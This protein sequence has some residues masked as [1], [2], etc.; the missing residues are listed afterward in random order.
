MISTDDLRFF[1]TLSSSSSLAAAARAMDVTPPAVTQRLQQMEQRLG[2]RLVDRSGRRMVL[3]DEGDHLISGARRI[4]DQLGELTETLVARRGLVSGHLRVVAPLGFG[5]HYVAP[6]AAQFRTMY[7]EVTLSLMLSDR[8]AQ[9]ADDAWDL[10][11]YVGELRSSSLIAQSLAPNERFL[12]GTPEYFK[13]KGIPRHPSDLLKHNCIALREND[14]DVTMWRFTP[15]KRG[16][17]VG[18]RI[19]PAL[20]SNDGEVT[21]V[22]ALAGAGVILR[23]EWDVADDLRTGRLVRVLEDWK[24]PPANIVAL[25]GARRGRSARTARFLEHLHKVLTPAPWRLQC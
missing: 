24:L 1:A 20:S 11:L 5:R 15:A 17:P 16:K 3:T 6:V 25:L 12:C 9:A 19:E 22:W 21:R 8:P 7:P 2:L 23:S 13:R 4:L 14:E 18:V 10:K